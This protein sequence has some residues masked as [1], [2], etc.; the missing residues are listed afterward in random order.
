MNEKIEEKKCK[1]YLFMFVQCAEH[2]MQPH[3][4]IENNIG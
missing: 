1:N 4:E 3:R 2:V